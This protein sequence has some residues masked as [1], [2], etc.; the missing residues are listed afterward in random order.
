MLE[1]GKP[2]PA[3]ALP[4]QNDHVVEL[5][6]LRGKW[7]VL[8][9]YPKDDTP[10]CTME[11]KGFSA[12]K[13]KFDELNAVVLGLSADDSRSHKKFCDKYSF[14]ISLLADPKAEL[15]RAAGVGQSEWEGQKYWNRV[16]FLIDPEGVLRKV[17]PSV[18]PDGHDKE[19]LADLQ[20][21]QR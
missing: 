17:Y 7:V 11:G 18:R 20:K 10:G 4:D 12:A 21:L 16:T 3:F 9:V 8:Y 5:S 14:A 6:D 13:P 19:V 1:V 2:F 15:L